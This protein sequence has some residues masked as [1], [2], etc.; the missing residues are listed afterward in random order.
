[1]QE[2][3][4]MIIFNHAS[5]PDRTRAILM[6]QTEELYAKL[7]ADAKLLEELGADYIAI[8]CNTSHLFVDRIQKEIKVPIINMIKE[9][10][11][12]ID[13]E[14]T[15]VG[16]LA[17]DGTIKTNLYQKACTKA[18]FIPVIPSEE[19]Q[20]LIMKII[21]DGIKDG[22]EIEISDFDKID[23][24][25]KAEGCNCAI[26]ACTELSCFKETYDIG[27]YYMDAMS[28]LAK[29]SLEYCGKKI[30]V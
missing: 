4:N 9:T 19:C 5:M 21:Y 6:N 13:K 3:L 29:K 25:L 28:I 8:P 15:K 24:Q 22:G 14:V 27:D 23:K 18:G 12:E 17:T 20:K 16:I 11:G 1:D 30:K 7:L 2:H 26:M 10:I